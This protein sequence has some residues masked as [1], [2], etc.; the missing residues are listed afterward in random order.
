MRP[1]PPP[2]RQPN[3]PCTPLL[4]LHPNVSALQGPAFSATEISGVVL[5]VFVALRS[6]EPSL[7]PLPDLYPHVAIFCSFL[8]TLTCMI[9][10]D[11]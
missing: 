6:A 9:Q 1:P 10:T 5:L 2:P 7:S 3:L 8:S 11:Q 4:L